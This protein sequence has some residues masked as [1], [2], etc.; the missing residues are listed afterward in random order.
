MERLLYRLV[1]GCAVAGLGILLVVMVSGK[2]WPDPI[3]A[4][5]AP[6][7]MGFIALCLVFLA[8]RWAVRFWGAVRARQLWQIAALVLAAVVCLAGFF[9]RR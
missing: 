1:F 8:A 4:I 7:G 2:A 3:Y 6:L 9:L 5:G